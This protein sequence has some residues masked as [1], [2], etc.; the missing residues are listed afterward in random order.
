MGLIEPT[1]RALKPGAIAF[2]KI[3][4]WLTGR[5]L[6]P[7][8]AK[9]STWTCEVRFN[10]QPHGWIAWSTTG[11]GVFEWAGSA[12]SIQTELLNGTQTTISVRPNQPLK[13]DERPTLFRVMS[14]LN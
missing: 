13:I 2:D 3:A 11:A 6:M 4:E 10:G 5:V 8:A 9:N 1:S 14:A 12:A 7:C